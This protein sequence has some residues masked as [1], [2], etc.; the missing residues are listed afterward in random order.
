M[1][2]LGRARQEPCDLLHIRDEIRGRAKTSF[3]RPPFGAD[4]GSQGRSRGDPRA[5]VRLRSSGSFHQKRDP[6]GEATGL[7]FGGFRM[8]EQIPLVARSS[9]GCTGKGDHGL[10]I[11]PPCRHHSSRRGCG[12]RIR[13]TSRRCGGGFAKQVAGNVQ[14][15]E[16]PTLLWEHVEIRLDENLDGLFAGINLDTNRRVAEIDLVPSSV[17]SSNDGMGH[18]RTRFKGIGGDLSTS[19]SGVEPGSPA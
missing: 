15:G 18:C 11:S 3:P 17:R 13:G 4:P 12:T 5:S 19:T 6:S 10:G 1:M 8:D 7:F 2:N 14:K 16:A 9:H